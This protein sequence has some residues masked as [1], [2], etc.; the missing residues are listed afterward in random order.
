MPATKIAT[1]PSSG[2]KQ[3]G[4]PAS[5]ACTVVGKGKSL[6]PQ[7]VRWGI[8][9]FVRCI[10]DDGEDLDVELGGLPLVAAME[11][12]VEWRRRRRDAVLLRRRARGGVLLRVVVQRCGGWEHS[13]RS[14]PRK[15]PLWEQLEADQRFT[16]EHNSRHFVQE[17]AFLV[18]VARRPFCWSDF[19]SAARDSERTR[20]ETV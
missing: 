11:R 17:S 13:I 4:K 6:S 18:V 20:L 7:W 19:V 10:V 12:E 15:T 16:F 5:T 9:P 8:S 2:N 14:S 3:K 1:D